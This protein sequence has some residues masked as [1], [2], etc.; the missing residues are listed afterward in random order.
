M[1]DLS[2]KGQ[3][4]NNKIV[5][6][7]KTDNKE[8]NFTSG[9]TISSLNSND[10]FKPISTKNPVSSDPF[11]SGLNKTSPNSIS[12]IKEPV[13]KADKEDSRKATERKGTMFVSWGYNRDY[14]T[15]SDL[16]FTGPGYDF[17]LK[18]V[19]AKDRQSPFS[20][21][22]Y[23]NPVNLS[24]P[25]YNLKIGYYLDDKH[26]LSISQDHMKYVMNADQAASITGSIHAGTPYDGDYNND[27]IVVSPD[28]LQFEHTNGLNYTELSTGITE[29]LWQSKN[30][31]HALSLNASIGGGPVVPRSDVT[32]F[33]VHG[34]NIF[35]LAGYGVSG[36]VGLKADITKNIFIQGD[37]KSGYINLPDVLT[38]GEQRADHHFGFMEAYVTAGY[39]FKVGKK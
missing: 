7:P 2:I 9:K 34:D 37:V 12:E 3:K 6:S 11:A 19:V 28:L 22:T 29:P 24:I 15:Q 18:D 27:P 23:L 14:F 17:T 10:L 8:K 32:L 30:G 5:V 1:S 4:L 38:M 33:G 26:Y 13:I 31:K 35:H 36:T 20:F 16:H 25:Q 21:D 39:S